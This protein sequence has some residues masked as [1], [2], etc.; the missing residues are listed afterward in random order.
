MKFKVVNGY[1]QV[2]LSGVNIYDVEKGYILA[3]YK[4]N[5][6]NK[7]QTARDLGIAL[8]TLYRKLQRWGMHG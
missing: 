1:V 6:K 3:R 8:K 7:R 4:A 2:P 5:G